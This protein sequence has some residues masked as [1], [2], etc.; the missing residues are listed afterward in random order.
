MRAAVKSTA[1]GRSSLA[2]RTKV[3]LQGEAVA[4]SGQKYRC[5][6]ELLRAAVKSTAA[7]R[8]RRAQR[9]AF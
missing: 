1:A 6:A 8:A 9:P 2:Q 5:R 7:S 4:C 3:P